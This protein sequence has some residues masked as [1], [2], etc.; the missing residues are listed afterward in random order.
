MNLLKKIYP[1]III[2]VV[3][4]ILFFTNYKP[5][6]WLTG[7]DNLHTE[8]NFTANIIDRSLFGVWQEYQGPGI[9]SGNAHV[10]DLPRQIGLLL[11]SLILPASMLRYVYHFFCLGIGAT[12]LYFL[13]KKFLF[14]KS[15]QHVFPSLIGALAYLL[16]LGTMQNFYVPYEAF[17][18][19]Y[20]S[21]PWLL[22]FLFHLLNRWNKRALLYF[23][24][25]NIL[26][27][28]MFYIPTIFIVYCCIFIIICGGYFL[29]HKRDALKKIAVVA[30]MFF[31]INAY[32]LLPFGYFVSQG[33]DFVS[34]AKINR[35]FTQ[36][37]FLRNQKFGKIQDVAQFKG[38][39]FDTT[40]LSDSQGNHEYMLAQW[41]T[42][43]QKPI[44][45]FVLY[46]LFFCS[47]VGFIYGVK[48]K[49]PFFRSLALI[50]IICLIAL[51]NDNI[52][53][54]F[55]FTF[56]Q[57]Y[58]PLFKQVF[59]FPY[60]KFIVPTIMCFAIG[61]ASSTILMSKSLHKISRK[62]LSDL[63]PPILMTVFTLLFLITQLPSFQGNL[64]YKHMRVKI[65]DE[66]FSLFDFFNT[67]P[68]NGKIANFPQPNFW[69]WVNYDW[70]Y[71]GSGIPW[72]GIKQPIMDRAFDVWSPQNESFYRE[73]T[74][75][76][77]QKNI[78][79]LNKVFQKYGIS[80]IW[81]DEHVVI[82]GNNGM[83]FNSELKTMLDTQPFYK[84]IFHANKQTV[85]QFFQPSS[86]PITSVTAHEIQSIPSKLNSY[87]F[88]YDRFGP[89]ETMSDSSTNFVFSDLDGIDNQA[90]TV[91]PSGELV[92]SH[93]MQ[94]NGI[95]TI[96]SVAQYPSNIA[97]SAS[98]KESTI[99]FT[100][101]N[102]LMYLNTHAIA[103]QN[104]TIALALPFTPVAS[105][106]VQINNNIINITSSSQVELNDSNI[107]RIY[108]GNSTLFPITQALANA[109]FNN[110]QD[111]KSNRS[112]IAMG[113][114]FGSNTFTLSG[115]DSRPCLYSRVSD[116]LGT[117]EINT[118]VDH[119]ILSISFSY[120]T[121]TN[122]QIR[123]CFT[124]EKETKCFFQVVIPRGQ[125]NTW[126]TAQY[127]I[128]LEELTPQ[129]TW[130]TLELVATGS[131]QENTASFKDIQIRL[132]QNILFQTTFSLNQSL[133]PL[134]TPIKKGDILT[135][136]IPQPQNRIVIDPADQKTDKKNC[137]ALGKGPYNK[138][139]MNDPTEGDYI[140]FSAQDSSSC[141]YFNINSITNNPG[142]ITSIDSRNISG[143]PLKIGIK[144]DPPGYYLFEE[145]L[146]SSKTW[147]THHII[148]PPIS[149]R[150]QYFLEID[151][152][153][154]GDEKR[155]NDLGHIQVIPFPYS[156]ITSIYTGQENHRI[157]SLQNKAQYTPVNYIRLAPFL[158]KAQFSN[159]GTNTLLLSESY[160]A[161]WSAYLFPMNS[162]VLQMVFFTLFPFLSDSRIPNH[163]LVNNWA[164]GWFINNSAQN[165][166]V[167]IYL[168]QYLEFLGFGLLFLCL[169]FV[170][171]SKTK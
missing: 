51:I 44:I 64:I 93:T 133:Q 46:F 17:S 111:S 104:T 146:P 141:D 136:Q 135:I 61:V 32:W 117:N 158:Y 98:L 72:Y 113:S 41:N 140:R 92:F 168:P 163:V 45:S 14:A 63:Y 34:N 90:V 53:T 115:I 88:V 29:T 166:I 103:P 123:L 43:I 26:A 21:L 169:I 151:N 156:W 37:A 162:G 78:T 125:P 6:T 118:S 96:P 116:L 9:L 99:L 1:I 131:S 126:A 134:T 52:P 58:V 66:Y 56:M 35:I 157:I 30:I 122:E 152:Y 95:L 106:L 124:K 132:H 20:A 160:N 75:A 85:Y 171:K 16:N 60:T 28:P 10:A 165:Q 57:R 128:P 8:F 42:Y 3:V 15:T 100:L 145:I 153:A 18:H 47:I 148:T 143:R 144:D 109:S 130:I 69:G 149:I 23:A 150:T 5:G 40:D 54:G 80:Y 27:I 82:P 154:V 22:F 164:N 11:L 7:W 36:E 167:I 67:Q 73:I 71:R 49:K 31:S 170:L 55:I 4:G 142:F 76:L 91:N 62:K 12:G 39:L 139:I 25:S 24:F 59:R 13:L 83:L 127:Q 87:D 105:D 102:P 94:N 161:G 38:F 159:F 120:L 2:W 77:Y 65:P 81:I 137:F 107:V 119:Q 112:T 129:N 79:L 68:G 50:Y 19:F 48:E 121:K 155:I 114:P 110:C 86:L 33:T 147:I 89:Y 101:Q 84:E 138:Q 70:G 108:K 74:Y 97:T